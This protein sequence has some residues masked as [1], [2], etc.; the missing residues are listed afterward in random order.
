MD[1]LQQ[2]LITQPEVGAV[3]GLVDHVKLLNADI[4]GGAPQIPKSAALIKQLLFF[5]DGDV[6]RTVVDRK[7]S[8]T[9]ISLR[10]K[11]DDTSDISRFL[12][13]LQPRLAQL[14]QGLTPHVTAMRC[15]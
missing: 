5:G 14:S 12:D 11:V 4:G 7:R 10:L 9:L 15:C 2:W 3:S 8:S 6:L 13:R 1:K